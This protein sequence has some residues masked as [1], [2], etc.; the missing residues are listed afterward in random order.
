[1][2]FRPFF[3]VARSCFRCDIMYVACPVLP[4]VQAP[5]GFVAA[6][7]RPFLVVQAL[8]FSRPAKGFHPLDPQPVRRAAGVSQLPRW[9]ALVDIKHPLSAVALREGGCTRREP[10]FLS[11]HSCWYVT[12]NCLT[13][14]QYDPASVVSQLYAVA[15][16]QRGCRTVLSDTSDLSDKSDKKV[17]GKH[18]GKPLAVI[19]R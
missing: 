1:M 10:I 15:S 5:G 2:Q 7:E 3:Q 19:H 14:S 18:D 17:H 9:A 8:H 6:T 13:A 16:A 4:C 11:A 12:R